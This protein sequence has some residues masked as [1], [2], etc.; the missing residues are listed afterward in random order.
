MTPESQQ[1]QEE[2]QQQQEE[3]RQSMLAQV[4]QP[5]A[6][7]RCEPPLGF[8]MHSNVEE[9]SSRPIQTVSAPCSTAWIQTACRL[10]SCGFIVAG[11]AVARIALVKPE[12]AR[13][14]ESL[15]LQMAQ[16]GQITEKVGFCLS[17][18]YV[19]CSRRSQQALGFLVDYL[20]MGPSKHRVAF[21]QQGVPE[22]AS[23]ESQDDIMYGVV[24]GIR[25][26]SYRSIRADRAA[27]CKQRTDESHNTTAEDCLG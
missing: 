2:A 16:R 10:D 3:R 7:E 5:Q 23:V 13:G 12:K 21:E 4:L 9:H 15:I 24:A 26:A 25:G 17:T 6:R 11:C 27:S 14:V 22:I 19:S 1:Q 18:C 20:Q 8:C